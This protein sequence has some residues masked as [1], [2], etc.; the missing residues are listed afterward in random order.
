MDAYDADAT[1]DLIWHKQVHLKV[2]VLAWRLL[3]N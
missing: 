2:S 3:R 1:S